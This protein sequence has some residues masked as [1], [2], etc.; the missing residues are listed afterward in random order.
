MRFLY[1]YYGNFDFLLDT[2]INKRLYFSYPKDFNDPFDCHPKFSL[3]RCKND[4]IVDWKEYL[5]ILAKEENPDI[6][7]F[8][9]MKHAEAAI[10]KGLYKDREWLFKSDQYASEVLDEAIKNIRICCFTRNPRNQMMWAHY[11]DN[12]K[13][14]ALQFR[15][16]YMFDVNSGTFRGFAVDYYSNHISLKR[17]LEAIK[18]TLNGDDLA[19]SRFMYCLKSIEWEQ[20]EEIR[21]FSNHT[22]MAYPE[23]M[24][25][26][27]LLGSNC[28]QY[29][30]DLVHKVLTS[31][32]DKPKIYKEDVDH[33]SIKIY[34]KLVN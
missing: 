32:N 3:V 13:G 16:S 4:N 2:I 22:Y 28:P 17:Y 18:Q 25:T 8:E 11:A 26:G 1:R 9:A 15:S 10:N 20:E 34:F 14:I 33:S 24:L 27:I 19:F 7:D 12:H 30:E 29:R 21:F 31:W 23:K 6:S 5:S